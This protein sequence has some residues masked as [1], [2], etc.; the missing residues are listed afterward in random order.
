[1]Y[2]VGVDLGGT[3]IKVGICDGEGNILKKGSIKTGAERSA[4]EITK[5][6]AEL[7]LQLI[8]EMGLTAADITCAGIATPGTADS[9]HGVVVYCCNL[10]FLEYPLAQRFSDFTG[11]GR[12]LIENDANA[13]AKG[14]SVCGAAKGYRNSITITLGTGVGGGIVIEN[15][16]YAG[17]NFAA[18]ELGHIV[19][20]F[21]GEQCACGRRGC[22]EQYSSATAL[23]RQT[24]EMMEK[25]PDSQMWAL[26]DG[27]AENAS[28]RTAFDA[29]RL[30][31]KA[32]A[33][34]VDTYIRY[35]ACGVV[36]LINIF[37][38]E[39]LC[40]GGGISRRSDVLVEPIRA[41]N[42]AH[43]YGRSCPKQPRIMSAELFGDAG[44]I[45]AALLGKGK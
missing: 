4:D 24:R 18:A 15:G 14:E 20:D 2:Y 19:I 1:M 39:V 44:I 17:F 45:G 34:V 12:V 25:C 38:P 40:L 23:T 43:G 27:K 37:Q 30:G 7:T 13:A 3:N 16:V 8:S 29:M 11:I 9:A 33:E 41:F 35:L 31:D 21:G 26:C 36:N 5:S 28:A 6:M 10:P 22:W 32:G 42:A